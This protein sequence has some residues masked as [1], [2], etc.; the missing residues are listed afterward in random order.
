MKFV[1]LIAFANAM[2]LREAIPN[3]QLAEVESATQAEHCCGGFGGCGGC[4]GCGFYG[5]YYRPYFWR[6]GCGWNRGCGGCGGCYNRC[7]WW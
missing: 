1:T 5:R 2:T 4:G 3:N 6:G 7:G